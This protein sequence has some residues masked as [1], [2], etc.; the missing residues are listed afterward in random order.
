MKINPVGIQSYRQLGT[1]PRRPE[2]ESDA[3]EQSRAAASMTISP[4]DRTDGSRLAVKAPQTD[5]AQALSEEERVALE[6]LFNRFRDASRFGPG[7]EATA[8]ANTESGVGRF[9]D[10]KV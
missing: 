9:I 4:Q 3:T 6:L 10:V 1:S 5:F 2:T 8:T 7:Y